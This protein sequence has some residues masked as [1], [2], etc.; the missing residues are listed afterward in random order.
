MFTGII[1]QLGIV[2]SF[3]N[4]KLCVSSDGFFKDT[5]IGGSIAVNGCCLT[6]VEWDSSQVTFDLVEETIK[7]TTFSALQK[8]DKVNLERPLQIGA[9]LDGHFVQGHIDGIG[10]ISGS[11]G[12]SFS[13]RLAKSLLPYIVEKGSVAIDGV[14]LTVGEVSNDTF[15]IYLIPHTLNLTTLGRKKVGDFLNIELDIIAKYAKNGKFS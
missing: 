4:N 13:I 2:K 15:N 10:E 7:R 9:R 12:N 5:P 1:E 11:N 6:V 8:G 14:S 3:K